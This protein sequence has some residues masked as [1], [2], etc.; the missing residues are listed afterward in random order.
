MRG[1]RNPQAEA[2]SLHP[3]NWFYNYCIRVALERISE[4]CAT[5]S[6]RETGQPKYVKLVFS[7]RGGH[8]YRHVD[9]YTHLLAIQASQGTLYQTAKVPDFR[10]LDHRLID[11][12]DHN[13]SAG[14]QIADVVASAFFQAANAGN[15]RWNTEYAEALQPRIARNEYRVCANFG[16]TLLPWRNWEPEGLQMPRKKYSNSTTTSYESGG[17]RPC[18]HQ[19]L[20]GHHPAGDRPTDC[21]IYD[22]AQR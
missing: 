12:I 5:W 15:K 19:R 22:A 14:C 4:W 1:Y 18:Y 9:T 13:K 3:H 8:S 16:V 7:R 17:S 6:I 20:V 21:Y 2:V 10:V 11:V